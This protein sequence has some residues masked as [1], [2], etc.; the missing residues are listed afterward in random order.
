M[1][2]VGGYRLIESAMQSSNVH[3]QSKHSHPD[4]NYWSTL[5]LLEHTWVVSDANAVH[6][7]LSRAYKRINELAVGFAAS[8][9]APCSMSTEPVIHSNYSLRRDPF[10]HHP[11]DVAQTSYDNQPSEWISPSPTRLTHSVMLHQQPEVDSEGA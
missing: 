4:I 3:T 2:N 11:N 7:G 9:L 5:H 8:R 10:N 6:K 1:A